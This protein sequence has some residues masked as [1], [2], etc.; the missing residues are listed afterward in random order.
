[1]VDH[2]CRDDYGLRSDQTSAWAGIFYFAARLS[3]PSQSTDSA[4]VLT[5]P[6][7]NG[8]LVDQLATRIGDRMETNRAVLAMTEA[9]PGLQTLHAIDT[10][11][12]Q[13]FKITAESVILAV[14]QFVSCR[15]LD[16]S[17]GEVKQERINLARSFQYGSWLVANI[18]LKDR[19]KDHQSWMCWDNV[20]YQSSSLGYVNA[21]HQTGRDHGGT[22]ITWYQALTGDNATLTRTE[23]LSLTWEEAAEVVCSDLEIMHPDIRQHIQTMDVMVWGHAMIQPTVGSLSTPQ[24]KAARL[25]IGNI[26]FAASDL[27]AVALFEE[28][29]DH[30]RRAARAVVTSKA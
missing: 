17:L 4:P 13:P 22:V 26:H 5:W 12:Q 15:L 10:Q 7:G 14:P 16:E 23:L 21:G 25:P 28:A 24:L 20:R 30:G 2:S 9:E 11:T 29:F 1:L 18:V 19:P 8:F 3:D 27:S 6:E